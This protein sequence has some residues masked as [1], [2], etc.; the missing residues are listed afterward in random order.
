MFLAC[1]QLLLFLQSWIYAHFPTLVVPGR[2]AQYRA[3]DPVCNRWAEVGTA[4]VTNARI[5]G[6]RE[7][8][9]DLTAAQV[10]YTFHFVLTGFN[11]IVLRLVTRGYDICCR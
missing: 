8:I 9:D 5:Q 2:N 6:Y 11:I 3:T 10:L 1:L 4:A 7:A